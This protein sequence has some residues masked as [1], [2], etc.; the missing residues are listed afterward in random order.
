M[1]PHLSVAVREIWFPTLRPQPVATIPP[2]ETVEGFPV[3]NA[4][5]AL[6][7]GSERL[8][9]AAR[10]IRIFRPGGYWSAPTLLLTDARMIVSK[11]RALGKRRDDVNVAWSDIRRVSGQPW[12]GYGPPIELTVATTT[13]DLVFLAEPVYA[14]DI[15]SAIRSGYLR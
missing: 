12:N 11:S 8:I 6:V 9:F 15:E 2:M 3:G 13:G 1:D 5:A 7:P 10:P 14:V 4:E